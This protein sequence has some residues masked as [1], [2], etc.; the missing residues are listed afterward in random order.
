MPDYRR[1]VER[2]TVA[3]PSLWE[4]SRAR[5]RRY[6]IYVALAQEFVRD[7]LARLGIDPDTA[8][9]LVHSER[10]I[11]ARFKALPPPSA[12]DP[13][14]PK[15]EDVEPESPRTQKF[16]AHFREMVEQYRDPATPPPNVRSESFIVLWAFVLGR[17][18]GEGPHPSL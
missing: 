5:Q 17:S 14:P 18:P 10:L 6:L 7:G 13:E 12:D 3:F 15:R 11:A 8:A 16:R 1:R 4:T 2:A 9:M